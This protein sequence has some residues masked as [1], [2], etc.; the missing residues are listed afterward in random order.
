[1]K[2]KYLLFLG[3]VLLII[4][5]SAVIVVNKCGYYIA[6][7]KECLLSDGAPDAYTAS[8]EE[9]AELDL[10]NYTT[11]FGEVKTAKEAYQVAAVVTEE[12]Y[13]QSEAPYSVKYNKNAEAWIVSGSKPIFAL[14][15]VV[16]M[17]IAAESGELLMISHSK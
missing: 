9:L 14:G 5:A 3:A 8:R 6:F 16:T 7:E 2:K 15:G 13:G 12:V 10:V 4:V 17:A 11:Q 1:M